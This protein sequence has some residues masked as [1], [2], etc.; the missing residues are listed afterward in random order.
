MAVVA[1]AADW[2]LT[3]PAA[4]LAEAF[5]AAVFAVELFGVA[6]FMAALFRAALFNVELFRAEPLAVELLLAAGFAVIGLDFSGLG[7]AEFPGPAPELA[8]LA[9]VV[10]AAVEAIVAFAAGLVLVAV[11][12]VLVLVVVVVLVMVL[13]V[14][15]AVFAADWPA[16]VMGTWLAFAVVGLP[17]IA[18]PAVLVIT[19]LLVGRLVWP[20]PT[21][22]LVAPG[23]GVIRSLLVGAA[24]KD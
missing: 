9:A 22:G 10:A 2:P 23:L 4:P 7:L 3:L 1:V 5:A 18:L 15:V 11:A 14:A 20:W 19:G 17:D 6:P 21:T 16:A 24:G 8:M 12:V 13:V